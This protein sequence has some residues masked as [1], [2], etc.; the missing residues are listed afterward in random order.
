VCRAIAAARRR[1]SRSLGD[2]RK[3]IFE[4]DWRTTSWHARCKGSCAKNDEPLVEAADRDEPRLSG[5]I[6]AACAEAGTT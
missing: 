5:L 6:N 2:F 3:T 1:K 4:A